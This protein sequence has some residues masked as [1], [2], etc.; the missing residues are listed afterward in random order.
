MM[1]QKRLNA[2]IISSVP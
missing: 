2:G 1:T